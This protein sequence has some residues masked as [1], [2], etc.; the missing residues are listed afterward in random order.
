[1]C[2]SVRRVLMGGGDEEGGEEMDGYRCP[3]HVWAEGG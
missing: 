3:A 2:E 1:M